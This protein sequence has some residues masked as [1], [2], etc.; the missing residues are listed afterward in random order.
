MTD[1]IKN[2]S[3][4]V[5]IVEKLKSVVIMFCFAL[6]CDIIKFNYLLFVGMVVY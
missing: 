5:Y 6:M 4:C 1:S 3:L 2:R